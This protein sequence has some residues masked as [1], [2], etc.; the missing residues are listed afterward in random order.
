MENSGTEIGVSHQDALE[1]ATRS[2]ENLIR[3][4]PLLQGLPTP[5]TLEEVN[6]LIA[7][8]SGQAMTVN[9]RRADNEIM[10]VIVE[11][12][13]TVLDLK[14]AIRRYATLKQERQKLAVH[15]SWRYV[16]RTYWLYFD[17]QK[18]EHDHHKLKDYGIRNRDEVTFIKKLRER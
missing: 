7:L 6:S 12:T 10:P 17:G 5:V 14:N 1:A 8:E 18:L 9:V 2:L 3:E 4:D 13:A 15:I 11:Q 16:W